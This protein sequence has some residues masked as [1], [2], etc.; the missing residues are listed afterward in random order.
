MVGV[1]TCPG[2]IPKYWTKRGHKALFIGDTLHLS[3]HSSLEHLL[4][5]K[6]GQEPAKFAPSFLYTMGNSHS[7]SVAKHLIE[8]IY[9]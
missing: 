3:Q 9:C 5:Q 2:S 8:D 7:K 1:Q 4:K 6:I